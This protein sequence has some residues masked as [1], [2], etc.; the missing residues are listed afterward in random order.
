M[1]AMK[2][3]AK[4]DSTAKEEAQGLLK[5]VQRERD[6]L[7]ALVDSIADEVSFDDTEKKFTLANLSALRESSFGFTDEIDVEKLAESHPQIRIALESIFPVLQEA[8]QEARRIQMALRPPVLDDLGILGTIRWFCRQF[9]S[10]HSHIHIRQEINIEESGVPDSLKTVIFR[11]LQE[12]MNNI[13]KHSKADRVDLLLRKI[14]G[15]IELRIQDYG[16]GVNLKK[17]YSRVGATRGSGLDSMRRTT[18][19]SGGSFSIESR[20]GVGTI[21]RATWPIERLSP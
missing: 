5:A 9:Q 20:K 1:A 14:D 15:A 17:A 12:A 18:E 16:Q 19:L 3:T 6:R 8:I 2:N 4:I 13:A 21:I 10:A 11:V 7:L